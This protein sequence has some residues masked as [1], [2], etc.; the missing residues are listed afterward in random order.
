MFKALSEENRLRII[1]LLGGCRTSLCVCEMVEALNL[2][3][4]LISK[5][6]NILKEVGLVQCA[7]KGKWAYYSLSRQKDPIRTPLFKFITKDLKDPK[8]IE[9]QENLKARLSLREGDCCVIGFKK[10]KKERMRKPNGNESFSLHSPSSRRTPTPG[11]KK[12]KAE[13]EI[14]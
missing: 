11:R 5:Q 10:R 3:Q 7:K 13:E 4:Y 1:K 6:L 9:D 8:F 2:P 14:S 12:P